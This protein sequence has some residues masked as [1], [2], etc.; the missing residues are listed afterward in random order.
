M[1]AVASLVQHAALV[2]ALREPAAYAHPVDTVELIETH[3]SSVLLAGEFAYKLKKPVNLGFADFSSLARRQRFCDE[4]IRLNRRGAPQ[5]YLDVVPIRGPLEHP[6]VGDHRAHGA[7]IDYAVRMRRFGSQARLDQVA[8]AGRLTPIHIDRLA[9][10]IAALHAQ[11]ERAPSG[12]DYG[13]LPDIR[14]WVLDNIASLQAECVTS[15]LLPSIEQ[16]RE[17]TA[18]ELHRRGASLAARREAGWV[19]EC[20]GDLHLGNLVLLNDAPVPFDCIEFNDA[21]RTIDVMNDIAFTFMDL[22]EHDLA[23]FAWRFLSA[24]LEHTG[25]FEGLAVLPFYAVYRALVRAKIAQIRAAQPGTPQAERD[26]DR[27]ALERY[28]RAGVSL[29]EPGAPQLVLTCGLAG[30]GKT[31][32]AQFM[33]E[34]LGAV[35]VRSD[36]ERKRLF[37]LPAQAHRPAQVGAGLYDADATQRT[38]ERLAAA[39][40]RILG[41]GMPAIVDASFLQHRHR[42]AFHDLARAAG[43]PF[44]IVACQ[45]PLATLRA[46]ITQRQALQTDASDATLEVL[47][48]QRAAFEALTPDELAVTRHVDTG[49]DRP[50]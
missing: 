31:T 19:R 37:A 48:H 24:Y 29:A 5:L 7:P 11:C 41:A 22:I 49:G 38:Y 34:T 6:C 26:D 1:E 47:E 50:S 12:S 40:A 18:R 30:S 13:T 35:R 46:R 17:W 43:V 39:A 25:D 10:N 16:L 45:A 15:A 8:R 20:H 42:Q 21:L 4:E 44:S 27:A 14:R 28:I 36:V 32:V 33:L 3:I 2:A 9:A 23:P